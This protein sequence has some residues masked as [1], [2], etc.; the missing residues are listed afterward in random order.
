MANIKAVIFDWGGVLI[1]DPGP[2]LME[3][4]AKALDVT[5]AQYVAAHEK[6]AEGFQKGIVTEDAF[7][8]SVCTEL[9]RPK[10]RVQSLWG[11]AFRAV[12]KPRVEMF[13]LVQRLCDKGYKTAVL[14]NTERPAMEYFHT[15][16]Y[17]M[18]D[19]A[20]FSC[21][22]GT[23]KPERQIYEG[24]VARLSCRPAQTVFIDDKIEYINGAKEVGLN[25]ILFEGIEQLKRALARLGVIAG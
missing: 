4:C 10:P 13:D 7:W 19:V 2:G 20:V 15:L 12:Y 24:T 23:R 3:Y 21:A 18:F 22:E 9:G 1:E 8:T 11:D 5:E 14:S 6:F 17:T 16:G 25:T